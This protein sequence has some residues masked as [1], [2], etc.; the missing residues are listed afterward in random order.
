MASWS[1][2]QKWFIGIE[3]K[4]HKIYLEEQYGTFYTITAFVNTNTHFI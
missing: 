4:A 1:F 3:H 2:I